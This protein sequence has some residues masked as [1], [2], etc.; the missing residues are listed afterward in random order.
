MVEVS[1]ADE[2]HVLNACAKHLARSNPQHRHDH[3]LPDGDARRHLCEAWRFPLV[4][5]H[6]GPD[7]VEAYRHN[8]VTFVYDASGTQP[9]EVHVCGSFAAWHTRIPLRRIRDFDYFAA[10]VTVPKA[11]VHR[12]RFFV[13]GE[14]VL[15]PIN[16]QRTRGD[17]GVQWSRFFTESC[18]TRITFEA[19]EAILLERLANHI[20]PFQTTEGRR[21]LAQFHDYLDRTAKDLQ[22][23]HAYRLDQN[24]GV[25]NFIDKLLAREEAH[26]RIDYTIC[27][28]IIDRLLRQ[29]NPFVD[30]A[31][32]PKSMY[33]VLYDEMAAGS[34]P[35]WDSAR[36]ES[37]RY[38]L[39]L[40]R[41]HTFTGAFCHP[42]HGGNAAALA[43]RYLDERFRNPV[44]GQGGFDWARSQEPPLGSDPLYLA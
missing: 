16:P 34:V 20:L 25:V 19:W 7:A 43:W 24:V 37:P 26:H 13:D 6:N 22:Y 28:G 3:G 9:D 33:E 17:N 41:R 1:T 36:Y 21:F 30:P 10:T 2:V 14:S 39:Q 27:L 32:M 12:Y 15:D 23:A 18:T 42:R 8:D 44:T 38:F 31:R 4:D 35:G 11:Q 40:L 29:R 5:A